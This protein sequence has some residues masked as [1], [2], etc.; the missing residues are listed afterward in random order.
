MSETWTRARQADNFVR[1]VAVGAHGYDH[2]DGY[3]DIYGPAQGFVYFAAVGDPQPIWVKIGWSKSDPAKRI[4]SLQTG[5]PMPIRL[6]GFVISAPGL[7]ADLHNVLADYRAEGEWF[8]YTDRV[9][10][11]VRSQL[12]EDAI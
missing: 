10:Q 8:E 5:C 12:E 6:L 1:G 2:I 11:I 3:E 7:E 9:E 4:K